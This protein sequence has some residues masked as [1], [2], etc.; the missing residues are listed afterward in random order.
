MSLESKGLF[1]Q[2]CYVDCLT[3]S[4]E[5]NECLFIC[6]ENKELSQ[7]M[8]ESFI[9]M[10]TLMIGKANEQRFTKF[11][12][13]FWSCTKSCIVSTCDKTQETCYEN[14]L[15]SCKVATNNLENSIMEVSGKSFSCV[16]LGI[17]GFSLLTYFVS[18]IKNKNDFLRRNMVSE[19]SYR[20]MNIF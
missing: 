1:N 6:D 13:G 16:I 17:L 20:L 8:E 19:T 15:N 12:G 10:K 14:C 18:A 5:I 9:N 4:F 11:K 7:S 3:S 2:T